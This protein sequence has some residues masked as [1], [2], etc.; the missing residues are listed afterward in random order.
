MHD[1]FIQEQL[2][3]DTLQAPSIEEIQ[4]IASQEGVEH[5]V[6]VQEIQQLYRLELKDQV[7]TIIASATGYT[8]SNYQSSLIL[9]LLASAFIHKPQD[10]LIRT[11]K[12]IQKNIKHPTQDSDVFFALPEQELLT[13]HEK[14]RTFVETCG[15]TMT[16]QL[17][18]KVHGNYGHRWNDEYEMQQ[19]AHQSR[20]L[21][22]I[23]KKGIQIKIPTASILILKKLAL[24]PQCPLIEITKNQRLISINGFQ[25]SKVSLAVHDTFDHLWMFNELAENGTLQRYSDFLQRVG[26]PQSTDIFKR[27]GELIASTIFDYRNILFNAESDVIMSIDQIKDLLTHGENQARALSLIHAH[28][29]NPEYTTGLCKIFTGIYIELMEQ[30]RKHGSIKNLDKNFNITGNMS[31][32]DSEYAALIIE[33]FDHLHTKKQIILPYLSNIMTTIENEL[34][35]AAQQD[36]ANP[37]PHH[38]S[39]QLDDIKEYNPKENVLSAATIEWIKSNPGSMTMRAKRC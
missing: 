19:V 36:G 24:N 33:I 26:N 39:I 2:G 22:N 34:T 25:N 1:R 35:K 32:T 23:L 17:L 37:H 16:G 5:S 9:H 7:A 13:L 31:I 10:S 11:L 18:E 20:S 28:E 8:K 3:I 4:K 21:E 15:P 27:E 38:F 6:N 30:H 14:I 29:E 12:Q